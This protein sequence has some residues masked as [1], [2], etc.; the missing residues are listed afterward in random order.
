MLI[1]LQETDHGYGCSNENY[2]VDGYNNFGRSDYDTWED[3]KEAWGFVIE[4]QFSIDFDYNFLFRWDIKE[5]HNWVYESEEDKRNMTANDA[6]PNGNYS[7]HLY[8]M[9]QRKGNFVPVIIKT[10][11]ED[12]MV[13]ISQ[14]LQDAWEAM[15]VTWSEMNEQVKEKMVE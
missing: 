8:F 2:Y 4:G 13:E 15:Q 3:F 11:T 14:M 10:I 9:H 7:M 6:G 5:E 1:K 12:D